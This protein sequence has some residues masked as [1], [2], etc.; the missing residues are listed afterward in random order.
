MI[1]LGE[2]RGNLSDWVTQQWVR[3]TGRDVSLAECPWLDGP[4]GGTRQ[5]GKQFF[6]DYANQNNLEPIR[7]GIRGLIPDFRA[8]EANNPGMS[9]VA[10][11]VRQFYE[12]TSEFH[13]DAWSQWYSPL[14]PFGKALS[15]LFSRR[16]QQLNVPLSSLDCA[17]GMTSSVVQLRH[18]HSGKVVQTAWVRELRA[19]QNVIYAGSYSICKVPGHPGA[20]VKVV[21]PLP[22]G[23]AI[24][25]MKAESEPEGS[26]VLKSRGKRFGDPG[27]YFVVH[28][29][30]GR[31]W[32]RYVA[33]MKEE[34]RV[35]PAETGIVRTDHTLWIWG[36][37]FLRLHYRMF[38]QTTP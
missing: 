23:S 15:I 4:V 32:T 13:L 2:K 8:L 10:D 34:I 5:I 3:F 7:S 37:E 24:V 6:D 29:G 38:K 14:R 9:A 31:I 17:R 26:L 11:P 19:T 22:N 21:F 12:Q 27:F 20:C 33:S 18:P 35:Y 30:N 28:Q 25:I 1:W 36:I 16:L